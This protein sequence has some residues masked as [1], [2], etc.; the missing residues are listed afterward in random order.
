MLIAAEALLDALL[1]GIPLLFF[2]LHKKN[3]V[4]EL[5]L[6]KEKLSKSA[7]YTLIIFGA[8]FAVAILVQ[9][10]VSFTEFNDLEKVSEAIEQVKVFPLLFAYITLVRVVAEE[11]FFRGFL[12]GFF[13]ST[14]KKLGLGAKWFGVLFSSVVFGL[15]H[16]GYGS[17]AEVAG[18]FS[19]GLVLAYFFKR[20][21]NLYSNIFA[22]MLYNVLA[23]VATGGF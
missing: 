15:A 13:D 23:L 3:A 17:V 11:F 10:L 19:L 2:Y 16:Y 21:N 12:I 1:F 4:K 18:A 6:E 20:Y 5:G 7:K 14:A 22:H 9:G 8:L